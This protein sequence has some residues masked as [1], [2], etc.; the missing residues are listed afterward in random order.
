M[1]EPRLTIFARYPEPGKAKT[2]LIPALG[3]DGAARVYARLLDM[4]LASARQ[5]GL[6]IELRITGGSCE[7]FI[8]LC[9]EDL[10]V[11]G[12]GEGDLGERLARV[13]SP[14]IVI[15]SDAPALDAGLLREARNLL[16]SH[17]VVIGPASDGGYY[18]I[19][20]ARPI[21]FTFS[22]IAW[23]TPDVL[24]ETLRRLGA[25]GIEPALLPV[26]ADIDTPADLA[27]WPELSE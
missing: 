3:P 14:A 10:A 15:G 16:E 22:S 26:L 21:P 5:S 23:S 12:Q 25:H 7:A 4:T 1:P 20:F 13:P 17:E 9:G 24:P 18:L 6:P 2:R 11:T 19:G 8:A 27:D